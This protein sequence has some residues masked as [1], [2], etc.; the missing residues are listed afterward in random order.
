MLFTLVVSSASAAP[1]GLDLSVRYARGSEPIGQPWP[2]YGQHEVAGRV[3]A[4]IVGRLGIAVDGWARLGSTGGFVDELWLWAAR[5]EQLLDG[6]GPTWPLP[7]V[8]IAALATFTAVRGQVD[9]ADE[10]VLGV[11]LSV[12]GGPE[13]RRVD[14]FTSRFAPGPEGDGVRP[15]DVAPEGDGGWRLAPRVGAEL[16]VGGALGLTLAADTAIWWDFARTTRGSHELAL[17]CGLTY[18]LGPKADR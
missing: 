12:H 3:G 10:A 14:W 8:G 4:P 7:R 17:A 18:R 13:L 15:I 6:V 11:A 2:T 16:R 9:I 1:S 5:T